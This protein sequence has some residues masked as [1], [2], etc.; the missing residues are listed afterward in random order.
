VPA[1]P[2]DARLD[3]LFALLEG[4]RHAD[5]IGEGVTQ[6]EHALQAA[7]LARAANASPHE[8]LAA[9][10]HDIG[11]LCAGPDAAS[12]DGLGVVR[13][14]AIGADH[15]AA[16]GFAASVTELVR[17]H[18]AAKRYLVGS[19]A[20]YAARLSEASRGTLRHQGGAMN[21]NERRA[22]EALPAHRAMLRLRSWDEA[23]K[24]PARR[25]DDLSA[26][27]ALLR[28]HLRGR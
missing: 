8:V 25:V 19:D 9:L 21:A 5:Y 28:D 10:L 16:L 15:L 18:V 22:F 13:H 2:I 14:E 1:E 4:A 11:H 3:S 6:L 26:Y 23:A 24:D 12:M 20:A 7:A 27:A 17:G